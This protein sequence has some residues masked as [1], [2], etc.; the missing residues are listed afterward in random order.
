MLILVEFKS[1]LNYKK[2]FFK[3]ERRE[4]EAYSV[5]LLNIYL[6]VCDLVRLKIFF[7]L[8]GNLGN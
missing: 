8:I 7:I 2:F 4:L 3:R 6:M 1:I 5:C